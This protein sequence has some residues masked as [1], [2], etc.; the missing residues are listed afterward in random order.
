V[1]LTNEDRVKDFIFKRK[2]GN[3]D[4]DWR[5]LIRDIKAKKAQGES[6][7]VNNKFI[8]MFSCD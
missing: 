7:T 3:K 1:F 2:S 5:Q 6:L 4:R 8:I